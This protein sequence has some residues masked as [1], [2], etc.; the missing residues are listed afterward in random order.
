[1]LWFC[2]PLEHSLDDWLLA[3]WTPLH[4]DIKAAA[5]QIN[6]ILVGDISYSRWLCWLKQLKL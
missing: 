3:G 5:R 4:P 6:R 1:M 2:L